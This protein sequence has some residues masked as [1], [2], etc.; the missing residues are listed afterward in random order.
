MINY[1]HKKLNSSLN[2][3]VNFKILSLIPW[4]FNGY[5]KN[6]YKKPKMGLQLIACYK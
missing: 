1:F 5:F 3:L 2:C 6:T 4:R